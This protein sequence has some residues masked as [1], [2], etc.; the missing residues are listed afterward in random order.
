MSQAL[1][2]AVLQGIFLKANY[3]RP[4]HS[5]LWRN[6]VGSNKANN[7]SSLVATLMVLIRKK[8]T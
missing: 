6:R 4:D 7:P 5:F 8:K 3:S 1:T 2:I